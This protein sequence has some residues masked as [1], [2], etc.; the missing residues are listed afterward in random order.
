VS[1]INLQ[2]KNKSY[3]KAINEA[4]E[5]FEV[6]QAKNEFE[7]CGNNLIP[8]HEEYEKRNI[9]GEGKT[10]RMLP[11]RFATNLLKIEG[12]SM[13]SE[14]KFNEVEN[15][16]LNDFVE[17]KYIRSTKIA[18]KTFYFDL[19]LKIKKYLISILSVQN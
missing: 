4:Y 19:S 11:R 16:V 10:F 5:P 7:L 6:V 8:I 15:K 2:N 17:K 9:S 3:L 12:N 1:K 14:D 13:F 18:G